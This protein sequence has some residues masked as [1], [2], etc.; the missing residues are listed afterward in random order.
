[1]AVIMSCPDPSVAA[2]PATAPGASSTM[3][4]AAAVSRATTEK[5][6]VDAAVVKKRVDNTAAVE[7]AA[8]DAAVEK[9]VVDD[10]TAV[11]SA[12]VDKWATG[13]AMTKNV[14]DDIVMMEW[15]TME[16]TI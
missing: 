2:S 7:R 1:M 3:D 9:K 13:E 6:V 16:A 4:D 11:E 14:A 12:A 8:M 15:A 10:T 5:E